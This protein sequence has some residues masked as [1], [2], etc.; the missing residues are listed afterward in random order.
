MLSA[1]LLA[2]AVVF[3]V[4][5]LPAFGPPTW[6]VLVLFRLHE[7][8]AIPAL[9]VLGALAAGGGRLCLA[10]ATRRLRGWLPERR[11]ANLEAAGDYMSG[12]RG[13][14]LAGLGLFALSPLPSAQLF[15][16]AGVMKLP[17]LPLTG[18][19]FAGRL[20]S[21]SLYLSAAGVA[22][23]NLG[24]QFQDSLTSWPSISLQVAMLLGI[25]LLARVD[26]A[27]RLTHGKT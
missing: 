10:L 2:V 5:L 3:G 1:Y 11:V 20:V 18:A 4:N 7:H 27:S 8:L 19:F 14:S 24:T 16:A 9:V 15:E 25:A 21:Y 22:E 17:L 26:W 12:H 23:K 6:A 13:R